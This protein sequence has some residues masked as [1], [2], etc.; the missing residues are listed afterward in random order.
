[1]PLLILRT[2]LTK[3]FPFWA[4]SFMFIL[5]G[6]VLRRASFVGTNLSDEAM[7]MT[8]PRVHIALAAWPWAAPYARDKGWA[9][10]GDNE[11]VVGHW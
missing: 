10:R 1:M 5:L 4:A 3:L 2:N 8:V 9:A 6:R 7:A 11:C